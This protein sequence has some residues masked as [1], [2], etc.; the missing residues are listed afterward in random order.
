MHLR[1]GFKYFIKYGVLTPEYD[2]YT[3]LLETENPDPLQY[4]PK[5]T[6]EKAQKDIDTKLINNLFLKYPD[7]KYEPISQ[8]QF[9]GRQLN[10]FSY[11]YSFID[12]QKRLIKKGYSISKAF[13]LTEQKYHEKMQRK[14]DQ[15]LLSRGLAFSNRA[16]S[17][18][19]VY[20]QQ[21]EY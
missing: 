11:A 8:A 17:F 12:E 19:N 4:R 13:E 2:K 16:R 6:K 14:L 15:T 1:P 3:Y 5:M 21:A 10:T 7:L 9:P 18:L 20:Q